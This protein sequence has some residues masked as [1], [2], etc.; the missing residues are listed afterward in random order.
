M[1]RGGLLFVIALALLGSINFGKAATVEVNCTDNV[2]CLRAL[3][4]V[5]EG[6][7]NHVEADEK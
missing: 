3:I 1:T 4:A 6:A 7:Q 2:D 5:L